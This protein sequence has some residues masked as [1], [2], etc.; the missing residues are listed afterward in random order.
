MP[1][2]GTYPCPGTARDMDG[3]TAPGVRPAPGAAPAAGCNCTYTQKDSRRG[4]IHV[5]CRGTPF[6]AWLQRLGNLRKCHF[7]P[8]YLRRCCATDGARGVEGPASPGLPYAAPARTAAPSRAQG[9]GLTG[10]S[11]PP[12]ARPR[13]RPHPSRATAAG[14]PFSSHTPPRLPLGNRS[15]RAGGR[16]A[17]PSPSDS[18]L[19]SSEPRQS[20]MSPLEGR[21]RRA[22]CC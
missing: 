12:H 2:E 20:A 4:A 21:E 14:L 9:G 6:P 19:A 16:A 1:L 11:R 10:A 3:R 22:W 18:A 8:C 5:L 7:P 15:P 13:P 17:L